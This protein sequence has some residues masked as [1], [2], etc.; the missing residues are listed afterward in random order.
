MA[1]CCNIVAPVYI[2]TPKIGRISHPFAPNFANVA[3]HD[4]WGLSTIVLIIA[5]GIVRVVE[6]TI[7]NCR[8]S[9]TLFVFL[10]ISM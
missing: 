10:T 9:I 2:T 4:S 7:S 1:N 8:S 5:G 3:N 6:D